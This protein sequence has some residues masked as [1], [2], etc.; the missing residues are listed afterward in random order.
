[1]NSNTS[2]SFSL[3]LHHVSKL[4]HQ[5][6]RRVVRLLR[7]RF[8]RLLA[9]D[10]RPLGRGG[11]LGSAL[12]ETLE[13]RRDSACV[14]PHS[15]VMTKRRL[16][17]ARPRARDAT[18]LVGHELSQT[19]RVECARRGAAI[20]AL[21]AEASVEELLA[22]PVLASVREVQGERAVEQFHLVRLQ[23]HRQPR[24]VHRHLH[25]FALVA[26]RHPKHLDHEPL[27]VAG[28]QRAGARRVL[29]STQP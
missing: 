29:V 5:S 7:E 16:A 15:I 4:G 17:A 20:A 23:L 10:S 13:Q 28:L 19:R 11:A 24:R 2:P 8:D 1:M 22:R 3:T 21:R 27:V 26:A 12:G 9:G 18:T 6:R 25:R 14:A